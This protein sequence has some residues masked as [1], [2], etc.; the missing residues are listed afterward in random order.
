MLLITHEVNI[1]VH[2]WEN[3]G[4]MGEKSITEL[5]ASQSSRAGIWTQATWLQSLYF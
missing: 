2:A 3:S 1:T 4:I 5:S